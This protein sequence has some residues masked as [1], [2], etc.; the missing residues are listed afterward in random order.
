MMSTAFEPVKIGPYVARNRVVMAPMTRSRAYGP[1][2]T[3]TE[4]TVT[5]YRQR[6]SAGLIVTEGTQP[7]AVGQGYLNT[8]GLHT[9]EQVEAWKP[10]TAAVHEEGGL[11]FAQ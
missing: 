2:A 4:L 5:Y 8:P 7:S 9:A 11:I 6:A 10:V 1:G 3:P